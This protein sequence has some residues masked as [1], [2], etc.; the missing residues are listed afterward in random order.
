MILKYRGPLLITLFIGLIILCG[1]AAHDRALWHF[2]VGASLAST[3][4]LVG[5]WRWAAPTKLVILV[6]A[7]L[8]RIGFAYIPPILSDDAYRYIWDGM[9]TAEGINP[10]KY[11]PSDPLLEDHHEDPIYP[12]LNSADY[13][14]V[15]PPVS[16]F[17]F[18][19]GG[20]F[21]DH[22]W[23]MSYYVMK[24]L[25]SLLELGALFMLASMVSR[26]FLVL[27][28]WNPLVLIETSGQAH[29][30]SAMLFFL[31]ACV[32]FAEQKKP[33]LASSALAFAGWVKL[34]P[35]VFFP[36]L[37]RRFKWKGI[38][39]GG[40]VSL[41]LLGPFYHPLFLS[42]I[43]ESLNLYVNY[44]EFNAGFYY[45]IKKVFMLWTGDDW[46]KQLG[47]FLRTV[48]L[49]SLPLIYVI[50]W[51][52]DWTLP[53]S[54]LAI[55]V[56]FLLFSTTIHPW[57]FLGI[58]I[59]VA[60]QQKQ[61]W[62]W[63]W[64]AACSIGTYL[65][66]VEGPYWLFVHLGWWGWLVLFFYVHRH[67]PLDWL[68][69]LQRFRARLKVQDIEELV[70]VDERKG[71]VLDLGAGEGYVGVEISK[72]WNAAVTLADV[73][74]MN[75]TELPHIVY[76]GVSLP[77]RDDHFDTTILYFVL[78][79]ADGAERVLEE[80][81]R[82]TK[83]QVVVVESVYKTQQDLKVLTFLDMW[84]NR[85]RSG[86]LMNAQEEFLQFRK[87]TEWKVLFNQKGARLVAEMGKYNKL[88]QKHFFVLEPE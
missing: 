51:K 34:Y 55:L 35:F 65:L 77:F 54:F 16:Q 84:A 82:V 72:K 20:V 23:E 7:I 73:V 59:L 14:S 88:H 17:V 42:N 70:S 61:A 64:L 21:Y 38:I 6:M 87:V 11:Y 60:W 28:A 50:D 8:L 15:Y 13:Y 53:T 56:A 49:I 31:V 47:P 2:F 9:L 66:Y 76:D 75:R 46:S 48:F 18:L 33:I 24:A 85:I 63:Q 44:F 30:E 27:Y 79:H 22:G 25:L 4:V 67:N 80:A 83:R 36:L 52:F 45:G 41:I 29:T 40:I 74:D 69:S 12:L 78:H 57:Y 39:P 68:Q 71:N 26:A 62:H 10:F 43:A 37:W 81:L 32:W 19:G 3:L 86:G 1:Y 58:L 5:I